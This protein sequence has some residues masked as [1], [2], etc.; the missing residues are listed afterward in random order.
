MLSLAL[1]L[2]LAAGCGSRPQSPIPL[3]EVKGTVNYKGQPLAKGTISFM[4]VGGTN[5]ASGE[6]ENGVYSLSTFVK[7]D[8]APPGDYKVA[9]SAWEKEPEMG[10]EGVPAIPRKY[11]DA[12]QSLLTASISSEKSQIKDFDLQ[13]E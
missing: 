7:G 1:V 9:V 12:S 5:T 8:G 3:S 13:D 11:L 6:I 2:A 10:V 4:P